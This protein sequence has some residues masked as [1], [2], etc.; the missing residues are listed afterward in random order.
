MRRDFFWGGFEALL[1]LQNESWRLKER[2]RGWWHRP[3]WEESYN[4]QVVEK[5]QDIFFKNIVDI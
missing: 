4:V 3:Q 5:L 2:L 1:R